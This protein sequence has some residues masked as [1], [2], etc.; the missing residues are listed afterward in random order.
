MALT[1]TP[2]SGSVSTSFV[3][4][5]PVAYTVLPSKAGSTL[6]MEGRG[7]VASCASAM[8][9]PVRTAR[10]SFQYR[11]AVAAMKRTMPMP[12]PPKELPS[13]DPQLVLVVSVKL[14]LSDIFHSFP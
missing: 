7:T 3:T 4:A 10:P 9:S 8:A 2:K 1:F 6:L 12:I 5:R 13:R 14:S 11:R